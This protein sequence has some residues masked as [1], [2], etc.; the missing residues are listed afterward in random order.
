LAKLRRHVAGLVV[1]A[2]PVFE[3][4]LRQFF[5]LFTPLTSYRDPSSKVWF[6]CGII[7]SKGNTQ[8]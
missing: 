8:R 6:G 5:H 7:L 3:L 4:F 2:L 1:R